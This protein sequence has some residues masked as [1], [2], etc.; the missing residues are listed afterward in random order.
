MKKVLVVL[1]ALVMVFSLVACKSK[2]QKAADEYLKKLEEFDE[3]WDDASGQEKYGMSKEM[4]E[5]VIEGERVRENLEK[6]DSDAATEFD[7]EMV[8]IMADWGTNP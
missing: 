1:L 2:E 6:V 3:R 4:A 5:L 7:K 8:K